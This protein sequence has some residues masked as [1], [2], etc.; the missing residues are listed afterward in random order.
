[1]NTYADT[2]V[3][4][5]IAS[6]CRGVLSAKSW[7]L[8]ALF[9]S[10]LSVYASLVASIIC[11]LSFKNVHCEVLLKFVNYSQIVHFFYFEMPN[12]LSALNLV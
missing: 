12:L 5:H 1:M 8:L 9:I 2:C 6:I 7:Y 10:N 4:W 11:R 3:A